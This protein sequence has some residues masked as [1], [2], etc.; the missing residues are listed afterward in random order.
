MDMVF[1]IPQG[2][3]SANNA[4]WTSEI[5]KMATMDQIVKEVDKNR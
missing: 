3:F 5:P 4:N 1:G 2:M